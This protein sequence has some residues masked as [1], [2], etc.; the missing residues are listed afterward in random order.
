M[1]QQNRQAALRLD[2]MIAEDLTKK[3]S[4]MRE[5]REAQRKVVN[6]SPTGVDLPLGINNPVN[7]SEVDLSSCLLINQLGMSRFYLHST[8]SAV[9]QAELIELSPQPPSPPDISA[10]E[11]DLYEE[12]LEVSRLS[13]SSLQRIVHV[14]VSS[15]KAEDGYRL[16]VWSPY[17]NGDITLQ[18]FLQQSPPPLQT[19]LVRRIMEQLLAGLVYLHSLDICH[20][21]ISAES[22]IMTHSGATQF[23]Q[24]GYYGRLRCTLDARQPDS[25]LSDCPAPNW[26]PPECHS[27]ASVKEWSKSADIFML[28]Q[29]LLKL[30]VGESYWRPYRSAAD[31]LKHC[32]AIQTLPE[33]MQRVLQGCL[34]G[35]DRNRPSAA[36]L[37][38]TFQTKIDAFAPL[39]ALLRNDNQQQQLLLQPAPAGRHNEAGRQSLPIFDRQHKQAQRDRMLF[40]QH[41]HQSLTI[42][43]DVSGGG[44]YPKTFSRYETD[45]EELEFL[46]RGGFGDVVKARN[47]LDGRYSEY[48]RKILREVTTLSRLHHEYVV[49]Y[50]QAWLESAA[51]ERK[52][53]ASDNT[54][55]DNNGPSSYGNDDQETVSSISS[56]DDAKRELS[57][58]EDD[59]MLSLSMDRLMTD[60]LS[61]TRR[62][63]SGQNSGSSS[64]QFIE[65]VPDDH[66]DNSGQYEAEVGQQSNLEKSIKQ[67]HLQG[68][69]PNTDQST[70]LFGGGISKGQ[71]PAGR[72]APRRV[73]YRLLYIQMEYCENKNLKSVIDEGPMDSKSSWRLFRQILEGLVHIHSQGVIHR[74]LKPTNIFL[75]S[76]G[77]VKIG[78]FGL[79]TQLDLPDSLIPA[80]TA[81]VATATASSS[82]RLS[83]LG[84]DPIDE[85]SGGLTSAVGTSFYIGT[86]IFHVQFLSRAIFRSS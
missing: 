55:G 57:S 17:S 30:L 85:Q 77:D 69:K 16:T 5:R 29:L 50:Y 63:G 43:N 37:L 40:P 76:N 14:S 74:D 11:N 42:L 4:L 86:Y 24:I 45:F 80:S 3:R 79:A 38:D 72:F 33:S 51:L 68:T 32:S 58:E 56:D 26:L 15:E 44:E 65:F 36:R 47:R 27:P 83:R 19:T 22:I 60:W 64:M 34:D 59:A 66:G 8:G 1:A 2:Q 67:L 70:V 28:G 73:T 46:G 12:L 41:N 25:Y 35:N 39:E 10:F 62:Q 81:A 71:H 9:Y 23:R 31:M 18:S 82:K 75:D 78:D 48:N 61:S 21:Y 7:L 6:D 54:E 49:R 20:R 52:V 84:S 13:H 53:V